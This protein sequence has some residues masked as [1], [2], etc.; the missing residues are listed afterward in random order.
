M[1][2]FETKID[3]LIKWARGNPQPPLSIELIPTDKCNLNCSSCWR[4][5]YTKEELED[6]YSKEMS[7]DRLFE[8]IDEA[9]EMGVAEIIFVGGGEPFARD[10]TPELINR[11]KDYGMEGDLVTNGT[12]LN[13]EIIHNL[14]RKGWNRIKFS[15][16]GPNPK[17]H[18]K[19][20]GKPGAFEKTI[21]NIKYTSKVRDRIGKEHPKLLFNTVVSKRNYK[22]LREVVKLAGKLGMDGIQ[23]LPT[24][25]FSESSKK[26]QLS[27]EQTHEL[28]KIIKDCVKLSESL[29]MAEGN[30]S[31]YTKEKYI[32]ET[33]SMHKVHMEELKEQFSEDKLDEI[34]SEEYEKSEEPLENFKYLPCY[35]PWHHITIRPNGNIAPCFSP[36]VW[37]TE[38]TVKESSLRELWYGDY[39]DSYREKMLERNLPN[40]CK[41]CCPWEVFNN[42]EIRKDLDK[43]FRS[44]GE[45][46]KGKIEKPLS[47][48]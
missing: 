14:I 36:W 4:Q 25:A 47:K 40:Q 34:I 28:I 16:D 44:W 27:R 32:T 42:R 21:D 20:R 43:N 15:V 41:K 29:G 35:A 2:L 13:R 11:I 23:L 38:T 12:L 18:D 37:E 1:G 7:D 22:K 45:K 10:I 6:I 17:I 39:F 24:T 31:E 19:L 48:S 3:R 30:L 5:G 9:A 8:L 46:I 26:M 33:E